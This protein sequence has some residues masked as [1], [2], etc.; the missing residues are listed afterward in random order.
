MRPGHGPG[1][2]RP[3][4]PP[5]PNFPATLSLAPCASLPHRPSP[6][7]AARPNPGVPPRPSNLSDPVPRPALRP[8]GKLGR[9]GA[10]RAALRP[11]HCR[12]APPARAK[13]ARLG[14]EAGPAAEVGA[15]VPPRPP[16]PGKGSR[17]APGSTHLQ[18]LLPT[19]STGPIARWL[20]GAPGPRWRGGAEGAEPPWLASARIKPQNAAHPPGPRSQSKGERV[21]REWEA[22]DGRWEKTVAASRSG[23]GGIPRQLPR[24]PGTPA[25]HCASLYPGTD[26]WPGP[27]APARGLNPTVPTR[28]LCAPPLPH[29]ARRPLQS[30]NRAEGFPS[31][32]HV[33]TAH[34]C[35]LFLPE[36]RKKPIPQ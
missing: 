25:L 1:G 19:C 27:S 20:G 10:G 31:P 11:R 5:G 4:P 22:S 23:T 16:R 36:R 3:L 21:G 2:A 29:P 33:S 14:A 28:H 8:P 7:T 18:A 6:A 17:V 15:Q 13:L 9:A 34:Q 26:R 30:E 24:P 32:Q 12:C 35:L